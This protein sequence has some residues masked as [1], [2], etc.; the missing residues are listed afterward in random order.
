MQRWFHGVLFSLVVLGVVGCSNDSA[1]NP[2]PKADTSAGRPI[3]PPPP[4]P[5]SSSSPADVKPPKPADTKPPK[6]T[7]KEEGIPSLPQFIG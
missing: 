6:P 2:Q 3:P 7:G 5:P 4:P 1:T